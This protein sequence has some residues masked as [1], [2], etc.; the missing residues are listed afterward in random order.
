[1]CLYFWESSIGAEY[2][3]KILDN[4]SK[5]KLYLSDITDTERERQT[6]GQ[7]ETET[8]RHRITWCFTPSQSVQLY[9]GGGERERQIQTTAHRET[10]T[11][12]Q[13]ETDLMLQVSHREAEE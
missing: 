5:L 11:E 2:T 7:T 1:M 13:R 6:D 3:T 4:N 12:R 8:E 10:G 9:H